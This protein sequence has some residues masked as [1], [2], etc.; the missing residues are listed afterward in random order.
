[1]TLLVSFPTLLPGPPPPPPHIRVNKKDVLISKSSINFTFN[2]SWFSDTNGA[3]KYFTVVVREADGKWS[4]ISATERHRIMF[5]KVTMGASSVASFFENRKLNLYIIPLC[6]CWM[7]R[8]GTKNLFKGSFSN[9][10]YNLLGLIIAWVNNNNSKYNSNNNNHHLLSPYYIPG[11]GGSAL[12]V[13]TFNLF[14]SPLI[15]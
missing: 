4:R 7:Q 13:L 8:G 3:V 11:T 6:L 5:P 2:C 9:E 10:A 15:R 14:S 12:H 1:M